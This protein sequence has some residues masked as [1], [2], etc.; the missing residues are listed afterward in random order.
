MEKTYTE[1]KAKWSAGERGREL[2]LQLM[3]FCWM[4]WADPPY[5]TGLSADD[6]AIPLWLEIYQLFGREASSDAEFL[7]VSVI[8][9]E[10]TPQELGGEGVWGP[11]VQALNAN[12]SKLCPDGF[13]VENFAGRGSYGDYFAHQLRQASKGLRQR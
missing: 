8:M 5:V 7:C 2:C 12:L 3:Y 1:L 10:I 6:Q 9:A 4:H 11:R 13:A